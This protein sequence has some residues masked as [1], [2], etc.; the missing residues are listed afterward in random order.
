MAQ[1]KEFSEYKIHLLYLNYDQYLSSNTLK[2]TAKWN[3]L[4]NW[5]VLFLQNY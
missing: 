1:S 4:I 2:A 3:E 5:D